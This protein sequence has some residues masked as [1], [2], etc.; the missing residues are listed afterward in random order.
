MRRERAS[1]AKAI[2]SMTMIA[3]TTRRIDGLGQGPCLFQGSSS[4]LRF[5]AL[6][7]REEG[8]QKYVAQT[9]LSVPAA[10]SIP[11]GHRQ[12]CLCHTSQM[13]LPPAI[14]SAA[15]AMNEKSC[16]QVGFPRP[17]KLGLGITEE[18]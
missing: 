17:Q 12:E 10:S 5:A 14:K 16:K 11:I 9:L 6:Q 7:G 18:A 3:K 2:C 15:F 4:T 13:A 1:T 8:G